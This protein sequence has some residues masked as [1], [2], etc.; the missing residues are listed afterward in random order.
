MRILL[1]HNAYKHRGGE[2]VVVEAEADLLISAGYTVHIE[3]VTNDDIEGFAD[4]ASAFLRAPY[5]RRREAWAGALVR[6]H[7]ADIL[8]IHNFWPLLTPA[9]HKGGRLAGAAVVQ[10]LHNYRLLCANGLFLRSGTVCEKCLGGMNAWAMVH[11]CYR[12]SLAGSIAVTRMQNRAIRERSWHEDVDVFIALT[13]FARSKFAAGGLPAER[14][15]V[16]PNF[17]WDPGSKTGDE[18]GGAI[19]VGRLAD[20]KGVEILVDAWRELTDIPLTII[21][22]G[23]NRVALEA[24]APDHVFFAGK[25]PAD[26]VA[27]RMAKASCLIMPSIWY[28]GFPLTALEAF[29]A[30]LPVIASRV[31]SLA[32]IVR[33]GVTGLL[34]DP[35]NASDLAMTVRSAFNSGRLAEMGRSARSEYEQRFTPGKNLRELEAVY[36]A[37]IAARKAEPQ[38]EASISRPGDIHTRQGGILQIRLGF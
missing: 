11:R 5:D 4:K 18:R 35:G 27:E 33:D 15:V 3:R 30:G 2:D 38:K 29:A 26:V 28:E 24:R 14:I 34:C 31:G 16:K 17:T 9:V 19:F 13:E 23:P 6:A 36:T 1:L 12:D 21:G 10:T 37:A 25:L 8:H 22:D 20:E 7:A 32:E